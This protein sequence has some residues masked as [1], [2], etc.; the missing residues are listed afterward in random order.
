MA[1][2]TAWAKESNAVIDANCLEGTSSVL[3]EFISGFHLSDHV[4]IMNYIE[5][6]RIIQFDWLWTRQLMFAVSI[7]VGAPVE[8]RSWAADCSN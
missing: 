6:K 7:E 2:Q 3:S 1:S 8:A 5:G 4:D